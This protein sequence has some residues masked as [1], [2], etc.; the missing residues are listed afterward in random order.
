[1]TALCKPYDTTDEADRAVA[2]LRDAGIPGE[3]VRVLM[4]ARMHDARREAAGGFGGE[5][6]T[7]A[8]V[9]AFG[10]DGTR[11]DGDRGS[12]AGS[13]ARPE[14]VFANADRDVVVTHADGAEQ[15]RVAGHHLFKGLLMD[16][17]LDAETAEADV[18]SLHDGR[19]LVLVHVAAGAAGDVRALL[20]G[21]V[22]AAA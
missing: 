15:V 6:A 22:A 21:A 17:G 8:R 9:G 7:D 2:A 3:D 16:A 13:D 18:R 10:G 12:F 4:A 1:M 14:G 20:D 19:I 11:R 5:V